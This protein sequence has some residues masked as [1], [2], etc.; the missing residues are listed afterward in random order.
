[1]FGTEQNTGVRP[2]QLRHCALATKV[3]DGT[4]TLPVRPSASTAITRPIVAL[5]TQIAWRTCIVVARR[6]S[7]CC[8]SGP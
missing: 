7:S 6:A 4:M 1:M 2:V 3:N 5:V 8:T